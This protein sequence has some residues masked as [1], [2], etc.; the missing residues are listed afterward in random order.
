MGNLIIN[1]HRIINVFAVNLDDHFSIPVAHDL[2]NMEWI[3]A[4]G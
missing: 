3:L 2:C 4:L 1:T